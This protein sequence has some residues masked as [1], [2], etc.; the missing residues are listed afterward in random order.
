M[1]TL[2][3]LTDGDLVTLIEADLGKPVVFKDIARQLID[4]FHFRARMISHRPR[5]VTMSDEVEALLSTFPA[6]S[7]VAKG[8][9]DGNDMTPWLSDRVR[10]RRTDPRAD[11]MFNDWQI[12]HLHLGAHFIAPD[13]VQ[14]TGPLLFVYVDNREAVLLKVARH[15]DWTD[16]DILAQLLRTRPGL[17][18]RY[19][20]KGVMP[21]AERYTDDERRVIRSKGGN[22]WTMVENRVFMPAL[23]I[24][25]SGHAVRLVHKT[26]QFLHALNNLRTA[27]RTNT[28]P[29]E[30][31]SRLAFPIGVPVQLRLRLMGN[32]DILVYDAIRSWGFFSEAAPA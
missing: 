15:G 9:R 8:F 3:D 7:R 14:R 20:I 17:M 16:Q 11:L 18:E 4:W 25:S 27:I 22:V 31:R 2:V 23:G 5:Q 24:A 32:G 19:E 13:K 6:I 29:R 10:T 12:S 21:A 30:T 26:D 1:V 28:T